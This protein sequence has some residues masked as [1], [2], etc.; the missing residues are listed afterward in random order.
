MLQLPLR[1]HQS[2]H[3]L[4]SCATSHLW[5]GCWYWMMYPGCVHKESVTCPLL[6]LLGSSTCFRTLSLKFTSSLLSAHL[7]AQLPISSSWCFFEVAHAYSSL[8]SLRLWVLSWWTLGWCP[9]F[10]SQSKLCNQCLCVH[11]C[12]HACLYRRGNL[13]YWG[14]SRLQNLPSTDRAVSSSLS[15]TK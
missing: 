11:V 8:R 5:I 6:P 9:D 7:R 12:E 14:S 4:V 3:H 13:R 2:A 10:P 1:W 15:T